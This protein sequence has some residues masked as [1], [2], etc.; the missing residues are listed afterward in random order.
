LNK[1]VQSLH[2]Q[3]DTKEKIMNTQTTSD[4][5]SRFRTAFTL[6]E[7]LVVIAIIGI[8]IGMLLPAVQQVREAARRT[9]CANSMRQLALASHNYESAHR[10]FPTPAAGSLEGYSLIAQ[11]LPFVEQANLQ[12]QI[13]FNQDLLQGLPW[14]PVVNPFYADLV[15]QR[16]S[17]L[18]CPSDSGNPFLDEN[19]TTWAG[20]NYFGNS[21]TATGV[22][23]V[24]SQPTD[25]VFWRGSEVTFGELTDGSSN[26]AL[27]A[28]TLFGI[29]GD[30]TT[31]L[32][33]AQTQMARV[34]GG[35]PGSISAE[36]LV[37][38][39]PTRYEGRR[40]GQWIRNL[41]YQGMINAFFQPNS[42]QPD[43][44]FHGDSMSA[45]RSNHPGGVNVSRCDGSTSFVSNS[46]DLETWRNLF[47]RN[48]GQVLGEF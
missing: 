6:V 13:D 5:K 44:A 28:E 15:S 45:A 36:D 40:A 4:R 19:G 37:A 32:I 30:S 7:L 17:I 27:L 41:P 14:N 2:T 9:Q 26:T 47:A 21:G 10:H 48:D 35:A 38:Q 24:T 23:Y 16:V 18:E 12:S 20:S 31:D 46:V 1:T 3:L 25:G 39:A 8:L 22:L 34:S 29:R 43:V 11:I 42:P 33:N